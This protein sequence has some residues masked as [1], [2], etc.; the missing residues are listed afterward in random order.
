MKHR[1]ILRNI[2]LVLAVLILVSGMNWAFFKYFNAT[3]ASSENDSV[4]VNLASRQSILIQQIAKTILQMHEAIQQDRSIG[5]LMKELAVSHQ[6]IEATLVALS[7]GGTVTALNGTTFVLRQA[8]T[9]ETRRLVEQS[10]KIWDPYSRE[11]AA[12]VALDEEVSLTDVRRLL[13]SARTKTNPFAAISTKVSA[14][15]EDWARNNADRQKNTIAFIAVVV[16]NT[17][18]LVA[19]L[20][21]VTIRR[22]AKL[23]RS[24]RDLAEAKRQTDSILDTIEEGLLLLDNEFV[25]GGEKSQETAR[26]MRKEDVSGMN[27]LKLLKPLV[28]A[29]TYSATEEYLKLM[30]QKRVKEKLIRDLNPLSEVEINFSTEDGTFDT[31]YYSMHF[32]RVIVDGEI[33]QVLATITDVTKQVLLGKQLQQFQEEAQNQVNLVFNIIHVAPKELERFIRKMADSLAQMNACLKR[34]EGVGSHHATLEEIFRLA[35]VVK[36]DASVLGLDFFETKLHQFETLIGDIKASPNLSGND[37]L[38]LTIMLDGLYSDVHSVTAMIKR[39][40]ALHDSFAPGDEVGD[41]RPLASPASD[42]FQDAVASIVARIGQRRNRQIDV[43]WHGFQPELIPP[44]LKDELQDTVVQLVRNAC[45]H[46]IEDAQERS[47][48][49]KRPVGSI[50]IRNWVTPDNRLK[51]SVQDDGAGLNVDKIRDR[52]VATK[53]W[54]HDQVAGWSSTELMSEIFKPSFSTADQVDNDAGRGVGLDVVK[55]KVK[56]LGGRIKVSSSSGNFCRFT[57]DVPLGSAAPDRAAA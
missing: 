6:E 41:P 23:Q 49:G 34:D 27:F 51:V 32:N 53:Q 10:R 36:G 12:F 33:V 29:N 26:L 37:F 18:L 43:E 24:T 7:E 52:L 45:T 3:T 44:S 9:P 39:L 16:V 15:L 46:G 17:L 35:H 50:Q 42:A 54:T 20:T 1:K 11:L 25:I 22:G 8:P 5:S 56:A 4:M 57:L 30:F 14:E 28:S 21:V 2:V 31:C 40:T 19:I 47:R 55:A 48:R 38:P 13:R